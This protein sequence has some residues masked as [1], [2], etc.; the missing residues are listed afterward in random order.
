M[1]TATLRTRLFKTGTC[2]CIRHFAEAAWPRDREIRR[3]GLKSCSDHLARVVHR[4][5]L[6]KLLDYT[7]KYK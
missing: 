2:I 3:G 7:C 4:T 1:T 6:V 5:T